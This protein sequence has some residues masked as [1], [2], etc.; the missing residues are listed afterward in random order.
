MNRRGF[1]TALGLAPIA[2]AMPRAAI[3][4]RSSRAE[5]LAALAKTG[6]KSRAEIFSARRT[7]A[8]LL[9]CNFRQSE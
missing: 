7:S 1:L 5:A 2:V 3:A 6:L 8:G 9:V 4:D